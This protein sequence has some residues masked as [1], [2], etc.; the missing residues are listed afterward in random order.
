MPRYQQ[1]ETAAVV[2][3]AMMHLAVVAWGLISGHYGGGSVAE[4][5]M[6]GYTY[7]LKQVGAVLYAQLGFVAGG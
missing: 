2:I 5:L 6:V 7:L 3:V 4:T 1:G